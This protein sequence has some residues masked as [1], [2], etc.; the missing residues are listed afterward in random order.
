MAA[1]STKIELGDGQLEQDR[2]E[3]VP[4]EDWKE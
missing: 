4:E 1:W 2:M 3:G